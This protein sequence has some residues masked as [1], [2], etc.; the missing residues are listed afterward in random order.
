MTIRPR[1]KRPTG[2]QVRRELL[3][4][5]GVL[6]SQARSALFL[7][8]SGLSIDAGVPSYRGVLGLQRKRPEDGKVFETA[9]AIETLHAKPQMTW[10]YLL[11]M[12]QNIRA[13]KPTRGHQILA[14]LERELQRVAV[15]TVNIDRMHQRADSR[16]VIEMHGA[17][18]DLRCT[19]CEITTRHTS[20]DRLDIP[21]KCPTC[22]SVL[23][24]NMPLFG[25][26]LP[27]EPFQQLQDALD[28]GFDLVVAVGVKTMY[29]YLARPI[30]LA[31]SEG[32]P[33]VEIGETNTEVSDLVDFRFKGN[34]TTVL[35]QIWDVYKQIPRKTRPGVAVSPK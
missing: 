25:E 4:A 21:P 14:S 6:L 8:G 29:S 32:L 17:L 18:F 22:T 20:F 30:L 11:Q 10:K 2:A 9:L 31:R 19:R 35:E 12:E 7:T 33:T 3:D 1:S 24:P 15:T 5:V 13:A 26:A 16:N 34:P 28:Q 27:E 23:R